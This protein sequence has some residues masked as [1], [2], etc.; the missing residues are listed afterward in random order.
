[1]AVR[2]LIVEN[3]EE[4]CVALRQD[5]NKPEHETAVMEFGLIENS[6]TFMLK[7][8][9]KFMELQKVIPIVQARA[10]YTTYIQNQPLGV[11]LIIGFFKSLN[12]NYVVLLLKKFKLMKLNKR[13]MELSLS[14]SFSTSSWSIGGW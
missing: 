5:L 11:V 1:L 8:L 12:E 7:N 2:N 9:S 3:K 6:I 14:A 4:L 10:L 13:S